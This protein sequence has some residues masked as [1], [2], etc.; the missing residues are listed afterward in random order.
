MSEENKAKIN[1]LGNKITTS[2]TKAVGLARS[3]PTP[4]N[5]LKP[6]TTVVSKPNDKK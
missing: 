1:T 2:T 4:S 6:K 3:I 5:A